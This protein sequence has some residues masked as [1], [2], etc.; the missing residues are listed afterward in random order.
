M[1]RKSK[2]LLLDST[3]ILIFYGDDV[4]GRLIAEIISDANEQSIPIKISVLSLGEIWYVISKKAS[5]SEADEVVKELNELGIQIVNIDWELIQESKVIKMSHNLTD[6]DCVTAVIA[7]RLKADLVTG[8][9]EFLKLG[10]L[11]FL[12]MI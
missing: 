5:K 9:Q 8:N 6:I 2:C 1:P 7:K 10:N 3:T 4:R 12:K 11:I